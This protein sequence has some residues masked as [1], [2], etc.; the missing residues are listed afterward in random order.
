MFLFLSFFH[1]TEYNTGWLLRSFHF[2][3]VMEVLSSKGQ[4]QV[5]EF[6]LYN[7]LN[8]KVRIWHN[9]WGA[10][11]WLTQLESFELLSSQLETT[12]QFLAESPQS[13][14]NQ[15]G[16]YLTELRKKRQKLRKSVLNELAFGIQT[17]IC[18]L[19]SI[20][21]N[22]TLAFKECYYFKGIF[23]FNKIVDILLANLYQLF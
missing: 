15:N 16:Q 1:Y 20:K 3:K 13:T 8:P 22:L 5:T 10:Q 21:F 2:Y 17:L 11:L 14:A 19:K 7:S 9:F 4:I 12:F 6:K 23:T 18:L